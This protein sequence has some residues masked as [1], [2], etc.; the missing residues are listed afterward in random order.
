MNSSNR[1]IQTSSSYHSNQS[2]TKVAD[3]KK[4]G[5]TGKSDQQFKVNMG[6]SKYPKQL[7]IIESQ[8]ALFDSDSELDKVL[9]NRNM[10]PRKQ[11]NMD[12]KIDSK[13]SFVKERMK[14][15]ELVNNS[16]P[17]TEE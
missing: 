14:T 8:E 12:M 9:K 6:K 5:N 3:L 17:I 10:K 2:N 16:I 4:R 13:E 15:I 1:V 11:S 7:P